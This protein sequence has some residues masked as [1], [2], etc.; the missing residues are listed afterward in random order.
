[1]KYILISLFL[2]FSLSSCSFLDEEI[3]KIKAVFTGVQDT[4][5]ATYE[6]GLQTYEEIR[7]KIVETQE[8][9]NQKIAEVQDLIKKIE[10]AQAALGQLTGGSSDEVSAEDIAALQEQLTALQAEKTE[11]EAEVAAEEQELSDLVVASE[12]TVE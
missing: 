4:A 9:L 1:M 12:E 5:V 6:K 10:E 11:A 8:N 7:V 3:A 2:A